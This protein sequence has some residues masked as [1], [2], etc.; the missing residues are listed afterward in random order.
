M[1]M[2][3]TALFILG[4]LLG[5]SAWSDEVPAL[6]PAFP[7]RAPQGLGDRV[8][9]AYDDQA[10]EPGHLPNKD[11]R[12]GA[13]VQFYYDPLSSYS[14]LVTNAGASP[15]QFGYSSTSGNMGGIQMMWSV[16]A[17]SDFEFQTGI[18]Y[19]FPVDVQGQQNTVGTYVVNGQTLN[20][21][22]FKILQAGYRFNFGDFTLAPFGGFGI[23]YGKNSLTLANALSGGQTN[24]INYTKLMAVYTAGARLD[25]NLN[26]SRT[27]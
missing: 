24:L 5:S 10:S 16:W 8:D 14:K 1:K 23:Y 18:D 21:V 17:P 2:T 20:V 9:P 27:L 11:G 4:L 6:A 12:D 25:Y 7:T 15:T 22:G 26:S 3:S 19:V 13:R